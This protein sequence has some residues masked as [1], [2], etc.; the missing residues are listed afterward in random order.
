MAA[1][2]VNLLHKEKMKVTQRVDRRG[3]RHLLIYGQGHNGKT[4]LGRYLNYLLTSKLIEPISAKQ[5][6][7]KNWEGLFTNAQTAGTSFPI[8]IDDIKDN[9][10]SGK[11]ATLEGMVK[12][13]WEEDWTSGSEF[14]VLIMNTNH[15]DLPDWAKTR[16]KRL[17]FNVKFSGGPSDTKL[18]NELMS[19]ENMVFA[20]FSK[21]YLSQL[22]KGFEYDDDE[23]KL[24]RIVMRNLYHRV[25]RELPSFFPKKSPELVYD[26]DAISCYD[27]RRFGLFE[28]RKIKGGVKLKFT[29]FKSLNS[30]KAKL[31]PEINFE[32]DDKTLII[33]NRDQYR[34]FMAKGKPQKKSFF[35]GKKK[36]QN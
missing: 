13:H 15:E 9:C 12:S 26:M 33:T 31:P 23:L 22:S 4:A 27:K 14:P 34:K 19:R 8:I 29:S 3:P 24:T 1:P 35:F 21:A 30:F 6:N 20:A 25:G 16:I 7:K 28:E 11:R 10:F 32:T 18:L 5:W 17:V 2:F 36:I